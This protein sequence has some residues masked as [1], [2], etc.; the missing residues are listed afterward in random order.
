MD[1]SSFPACSKA[2]RIRRKIRRLPRRRRYSAKRTSSQFGDGA[3]RFIGTASSGMRH[4]NRTR[5]E[6]PPRPRP[7]STRAP[8]PRSP[9]SRRRTQ[10]SKSDEPVQQARKPGRLVTVIPWLP[11]SAYPCCLR[12]VTGWPRRIANRT[13]PSRAGQ[14]SAKAGV[15]PRRRSP[16][17]AL[18]PSSDRARGRRADRVRAGRGRRAAPPDRSTT[19][20]GSPG[21]PCR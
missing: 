3:A 14:A 10:L 11:S 1:T 20:I 13:T 18:P 6:K 8:P 2:D 17:C 4:E 12:T 15:R 7:T 5:S 19:V 21:R 9:R 16:D